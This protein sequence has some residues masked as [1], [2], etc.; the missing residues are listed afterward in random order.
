MLDLMTLST[1]SD[2]ATEIS[3]QDLESV[4]CLELD[5]RQARINVSSSSTAVVRC[6]VATE[7]CELVIG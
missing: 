1:E 3:R 2:V 7:I 5:Q 4:I 6:D